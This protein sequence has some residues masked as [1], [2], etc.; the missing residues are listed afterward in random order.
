MC[1]KINES[2]RD[3][4]SVEIETPSKIA[5][6]RFTTKTKHRVHSLRNMG[7]DL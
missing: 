3:Y 2:R 5:S 4:L 6:R 7:F 1:L